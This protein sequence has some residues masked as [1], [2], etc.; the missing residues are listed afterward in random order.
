MAA[1]SYGVE[2]VTRR[3]MEKECQGGLAVIDACR[4]NP[5]ATSNGK[6]IGAGQGLAKI[7]AAEGVFVLFAPA[8]ARSLSIVFPT[9]ILIPTRCS[10]AG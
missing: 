6:S 7:D 10:P 1:D 2:T 9:A 4:D 8:W 5:L 3:I